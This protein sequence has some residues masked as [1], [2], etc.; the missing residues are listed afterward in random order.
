M[1]IDGIRVPVTA[2]ISDT[3]TSNTDR[4]TTLP[5]TVTNGRTVELLE[6]DGSN[7]PGIYK[8]VSGSWVLQGASLSFYDI[9]GNV[10][11][12]PDASTSVLQLVAPRAFTIPSTFSGSYAICTTAS[13]NSAAFTI[14]KWNTAHTSSTTLG[15]IVFTSSSKV[16]TFAQ[17]GSGNMVVSAGE[18]LDVVSPVST[19]T[20]LADI[21]FVISSNI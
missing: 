5:G 13:T 9:A 15:T 17:S 14:R 19:D 7:G 21:A 20:T 6:Q 1:L 12:K 3:V 4:V 11:G 2:D 8:G 16:G 10:I 18:T